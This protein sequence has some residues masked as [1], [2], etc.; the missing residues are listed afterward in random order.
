M[1]RPSPSTITPTPTPTTT[2]TTKS[3]FSSPGNMLVIGGGALKGLGVILYLKNKYAKQAAAAILNGN[4][5]L[6]DYKFFSGTSTGAI[7]TAG[8]GSR[9][10]ICSLLRKNT[11]ILKDMA[12]FFH[13]TSDVLLAENTSDSRFI[14]LYLQFLYVQDSKTKIFTQPIGWTLQTLGGLV[15]PRYPSPIDFVFETF[16]N[17][18]MRDLHK[19]GMFIFSQKMQSLETIIFNNITDEGLVTSDPYYLSEL[20]LMAT[21]TPVFFPSYQ[22]FIDAGFSSNDPV[23]ETL[24]YLQN[25]NQLHLI[26]NVDVINLNVNG[27]KKMHV[28]NNSG[29]LQWITK[30]PFL[31][32]DTSMIMAKKNTEQYFSEIESITFYDPVDTLVTNYSSFNIGII[33]DIL[34]HFK[35]SNAFW[36]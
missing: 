17:L 27:T 2:N 14:L 10:H 13:T 36:T 5:F 35:N 23:F 6:N 1:P 34:H 31:T 7:L 29:I 15:G 3:I 26:K 16:G 12:Q 24:S 33:H 21:S 11:R 25:Q 30:I 18:K 4:D 8:L 20:I 28:G 19:N 22:G 9:Y 32:M